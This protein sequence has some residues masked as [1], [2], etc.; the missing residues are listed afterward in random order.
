MTDP[1]RI[2]PLCQLRTPRRRR[3]RGPRNQ[4]PR[5]RCEQAPQSQRL[6]T[7]IIDLKD[8]ADHPF[9]G[10]GAPQAA[11][12]GSWCVRG[13]ERGV[14][15]RG[16]DASELR[17]I[18]VIAQIGV[19]PNR[20][21]LMNEIDGVSFSEAWKGRTIDSAVLAGELVPLTF[22]G[23]RELINNKEAM[24]RHKDLDD[25]KAQTLE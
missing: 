14:N 15:R 22:I 9:G 20:V 16:T 1:G 4:P 23:I 19:P 7:R 21:D 3:P 8:L 25:L 10:C 24:G 11:G 5:R 17:V 2:D 18:G 13:V 6:I 12:L